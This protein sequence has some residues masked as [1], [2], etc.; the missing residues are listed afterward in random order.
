MARSKKE[1][2]GTKVD[3]EILIACVEVDP[4]TEDCI[5][6][7]TMNIHVRKDCIGNKK[8]SIPVHEDCISNK[9][10]IHVCKDCTGSKVCIDVSEDYIDDK[11]CELKK[12]LK[13]VT[14]LKQ[15]EFE[16][17]RVLERGK[18]DVQTPLVLASS[19]DAHNSVILG[20]NVMSLGSD[21][22]S[23]AR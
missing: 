6:S 14:K 11:K 1:V 13:K 5:G 20:S 9:V 3:Y 12:K 19:C 17:G 23:D 18:E 7:K 22:N 15:E 21:A 16:Q 10:C 2:N 4:V 8:I